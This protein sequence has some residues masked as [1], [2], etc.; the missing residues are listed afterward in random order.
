MVSAG[1]GKAAIG[2]GLV[3]ILDTQFQHTAAVRELFKADYPA[4]SGRC[5]PAFIP[6]V[7]F[8]ADEGAVIITGRRF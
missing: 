1:A 3:L 5:S 7:R 8:F 6:A 4:P 2:G